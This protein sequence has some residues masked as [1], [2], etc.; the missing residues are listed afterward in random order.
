[1]SLCIILQ[2]VRQLNALRYQ[3]SACC[4]NVRSPELFDGCRGNVV[5]R[6]FT[7]KIVSSL[8]RM[9]PT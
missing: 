3:I 7:V 4:W 9:D 6:G 5:F 1:M 2:K 8:V